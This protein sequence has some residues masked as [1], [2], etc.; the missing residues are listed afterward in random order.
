MEALKYWEHVLAQN[1]S[2]HGKGMDDEVKVTLRGLQQLV[3]KSHRSGCKHVMEQVEAAQAKADAMFA[4]ADKHFEDA[5]A[6]F[7]EAM[8]RADAAASR[9]PT[10]LRHVFRRF[11]FW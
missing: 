5:N 6:H 1:P 4:K 3:V 9:A 11:K 7:D 10:G 8:K 2:L